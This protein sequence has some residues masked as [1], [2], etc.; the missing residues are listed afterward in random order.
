MPITPYLCCK[1][2]ADAI[3]F[4]KAAF[5]AEEISRWSDDTGRIS[6]AELK[7]AGSAFFLADEHP[8]IGVFSPTTI[9]ASQ[10]LL[11]LDVEDADAVFSQAILAGAVETRALKTESYGRNGKLRDPFGHDWMIF[12]EFQ[13]T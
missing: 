4:Y 3:D 2:A 9:G 5:S 7:I 11:V 12:A 10:V 8:E 6:H 1:G 13:P